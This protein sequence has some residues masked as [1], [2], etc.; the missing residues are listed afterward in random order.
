MLPPF[1]HLSIHY[2]LLN[3]FQAT[4][5]DGYLVGEKAYLGLSD[6]ISKIS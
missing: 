4:A 3:R 6:G 2:S 5:R 1:H